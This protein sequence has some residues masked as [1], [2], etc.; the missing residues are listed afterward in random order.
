MPG[1]SHS[2]VWSSTVAHLGVALTEKDMQNL[3]EGNHT[4]LSFFIQIFKNMLCMIDEEP[5]S[6]HPLFFLQTCPLAVL[7]SFWIKDK[8]LSPLQCSCDV[9]FMHVKPYCCIIVSPFAVRCYNIWVML[10]EIL[11]FS[12]FL[13]ICQHFV[14]YKNIWAIQIK[15]YIPCMSSSS[16]P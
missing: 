8:F 12:D 13:Y 4:F 3:I 6:E 7:V 9:N 11:Y 2:F 14:S 1:I 10:D 16:W 15:P 5:S